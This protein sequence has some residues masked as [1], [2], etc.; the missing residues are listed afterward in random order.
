[1]KHNH[2]E[3]VGILVQT[4]HLLHA[5]LVLELIIKHFIDKLDVWL[6]L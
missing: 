4:E 3:R 5:I 6:Y 1:M 2:W